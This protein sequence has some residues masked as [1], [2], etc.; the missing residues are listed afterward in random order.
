MFA[1]ILIGEQGGIG[2]SVK[3][4]FI[5]GHNKHFLLSLY[6]RELEA[7]RALTGD[8]FLPF[9]KGMLRR[10]EVRA[11]EVR[12]SLLDSSLTQVQVIS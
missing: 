2:R 3:I 7:G 10:S 4:V 8:G 9:V 5:A 1:N 12:E 11:K 6:F